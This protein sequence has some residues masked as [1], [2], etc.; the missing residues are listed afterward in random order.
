MITNPCNDNLVAQQVARIQKEILETCAACGRDP[1]SVRLMAVTKT[2]E[3]ERVNQAI[4]AGV[5]LLGENKAQELLAKYDAYHKDQVEIHFIGHLQTN[6]VRQIVDKVTVIQ[7][8]DSVHLASEIDKQCAKLGKVMDCLVEVNVGSELTKS[9]VDPENLV[10]FLGEVSQFHQIHV[11]GL[12]AIPPVCESELEME[13][14]FSDLHK[15]FVDIGGEKLDNINM[16]FLSMGMSGDYRLAI[17][18]GSNIVRIG[19]AMFGHRNY[20]NQ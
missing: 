2:V 18:H 1:A 15:L 17:K 19:T 11:R 13:A 20:A 6:K 3:P 4:E 16:D 7:S 12:M 10:D 14:Y 9:G 8:L 5:H